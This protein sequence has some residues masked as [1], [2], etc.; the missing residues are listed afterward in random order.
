M[1][2]E[3]TRYGD[4]IRRAWALSESVA[5]EGVL[6]FNLAN[7]QYLTGFT[8]SDGALLVTRDQFFLLVDGRYLN[9]A[10]NEVSGGQ[11]FLY[12]QKIKG[13]AELAAQ[14]SLGRVAWEAPGI[15][16]DFFLDLT[17][18]TADITW[19]P[20][21]A[22]ALADLRSVKTADEIDQISQASR[23]AYQAWEKILPL[24]RPGV[25]ERDIALELDYQMRV[26]GAEEVAFRTIVASGVNSAWP[27]ARPGGKLLLAQE[28]VIVD[29]GAVYAG[30]RSD[31][32]RTLVL[33]QAT[34]D[35][36][37][38]YGLVREAHDRA[39]AALRPGVTTSEVDQAARSFIHQGGLGEFFTHGTGHGVGLDIHEPPRL[40]EN[41][42][43]LLAAGNV[44][45]VEP[46]VYL[47][48]R[49]GI[50]IE[51]LALV[52]EEGF[53]LLSSGGT[54]LLEL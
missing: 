3:A 24:I 9:Q 41:T 13:I 54:D 21:R 10:Q 52:N 48:G 18:K 28:V 35:F 5:A 40:A 17:A 50:R 8:G 34:E 31:Q 22:A 7:I 20:L 38:A 15:S 25:R 47:P 43:G 42:T 12:Q 36:R 44:V 23:I 27:H 51:D 33:G 19:V 4:R 14:L 37:R 45:T 30:Y 16:H 26:H 49:W 39:L 29:W 2:F 32:T 11:V 53:R 46:G 1:P 6:F